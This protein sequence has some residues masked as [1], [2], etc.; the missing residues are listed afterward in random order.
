VTGTAKGTGTG[1]VASAP[2]A[3]VDSPSLNALTVVLVVAA[4]FAGVFALAFVA[5]RRPSAQ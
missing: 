2:T 3:K 4:I 1:T 5:R